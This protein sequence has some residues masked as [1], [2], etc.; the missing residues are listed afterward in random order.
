MKCSSHI[1]AMRTFFY[2]LVKSKLL[3]YQIYFMALNNY[4]DIAISNLIKGI[5]SD[6]GMQ[7]QK[8]ITKS[9]YR[10]NT[11]DVIDQF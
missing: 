8:L 11:N 4:C 2:K 1:S 5:A 6:K 3:L 10:K 9:N 7:Q